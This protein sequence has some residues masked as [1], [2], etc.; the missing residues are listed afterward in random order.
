MIR[1]CLVPCQDTL[2]LALGKKLLF[3]AFSS[4]KDFHVT[5]R[6]WMGLFLQQAWLFNKKSSN[7]AFR[8]R[9]AIP[10]IRTSRA[11]SCAVSLEGQA[12][13]LPRP[14]HSRS[15]VSL[16]G[17]TGKRGGTVIGGRVLWSVILWSKSQESFVFRLVL[18]MDILFFFHFRRSH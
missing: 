2:G 10:G 8:V 3:L 1:S 9:L 5:S 6:T 13:C 7:E 16:P 12:P 4:T 14:R 17:A 11:Q 18:I 15:A